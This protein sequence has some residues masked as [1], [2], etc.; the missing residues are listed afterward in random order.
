MKISV[1]YLAF[2]IYELNEQNNLNNRKLN[3][4]LLLNPLIKVFKE[5]FNFKLIETS[6]INIQRLL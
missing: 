4:K 5:K 2:I 1:I 6:I 3:I